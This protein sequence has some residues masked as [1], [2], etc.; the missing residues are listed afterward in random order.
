MS[1]TFYHLNAA[2]YPQHF[3]GALDAV[4]VMIDKHTYIDAFVLNKLFSYILAVEQYLIDH[5]TGI[6]A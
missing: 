3:P 5:K 4:P 2:N 6:E 1:P